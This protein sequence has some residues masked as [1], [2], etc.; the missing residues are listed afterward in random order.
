[1]IESIPSLDL[2]D[3]TSGNE[4]QKQKFV[5]QLGAAYQEIGFVSIKNHGFNTDL[6]T[7]LY[8]VLKKFF[9]LED[10]VKM[11]YDGSDFNGQRG[12]TGKRKE[13]AAGRS[14]GDLKE[15][16]HVG[17]HI[18]ESDLK[19]Y[20]PN[21]WPSEI[22][23]IASICED[24]YSTLESIGK[25]MLSAI[26]LHL[27]LEEDYF[28][29]KVDRAIS[30]LRPIHYF[31]IT[32]TSEI[33][34]GAVR[35]AEHGDINLITILMGASADGLEVKRADGKWIPITAIDGH[36]I[37]NVGD[38]LERLTNGVL[39]ST[40]HRVVNPP[41]DQLDKPRYSIP[42]FMHANPDTSLA[43]LDSCITANNPKKW[44]DTTAGELL[45]E[46]LKAIG[47]K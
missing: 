33:K 45:L 7:D 27:D 25:T 19:D 43:S 36:L 40:I 30:I 14:M 16:F 38:M 21:I 18:P 15:F 26:A 41:I 3:F 22:P 5:S 34:E 46:R 12:Y 42:F 32:D 44:E 29:R 6:E 37:V 23:E 39:K 10:D 1:M 11:K 24:A 20:A 2:S 8:N 4:S 31:P 13:H 17:K 28:N 35:A 9:D 47:L